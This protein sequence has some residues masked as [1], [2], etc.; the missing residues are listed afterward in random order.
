LSPPVG[1]WWKILSDAYKR[2]TAARS[3]DKETLCNL[4]EPGIPPKQRDTLL[5]VVSGLDAV[6]SPKNVAECVLALKRKN[7]TAEFASASLGGETKKAT[8]LLSALNEV[9]QTDSLG[10]GETAEWNDSQPLPA[11]FD[12]VGTDKRIP[13]GCPAING[14]L[15]GGLL[16]GHHVVIFGR[17]EVGK[18][19]FVIDC[20]ARLIKNQQRVIYIGNE[21]HIDI[22]KMRMVGRLLKQPQSWL[23]A[24]KE[25]AATEFKQYEDSL[26]MTQLYSGD[27]AAIRKRIV[28]WKPTVLVIDQF[29]NLI[30]TEEGITRRMEDN[31]IKLRAL[32]LE[33]GL[34]GISVTQANDRSERHGQE[35][36]IFLQS[37][38]VDSSRVGL[39]SQADLLLGIGANSDLKSRSQ[40]FVSFCKNK[41]S[42]ARGA[43]EGVMIN[44][45]FGISRVT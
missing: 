16:P 34:I 12:R 17:T 40:A 20:T 4:A 23:E 9:W 42:S 8:E 24:N 7:L 25:Q 37:G 33:R 43:H 39:P 29:R 45:D 1:H 44:F 6:P 35:P 13:F 21:D 32:L 10:E 15:S 27:I 19:S 5:G 11:L 28:E 38:D 18:S 31:A 14:K 30:G 3:L 26:L 36:P 41:T 22:L 2:D